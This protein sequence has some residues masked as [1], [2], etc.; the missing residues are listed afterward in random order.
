MPRRDV[1]EWF[2]QVGREMASLAEE[3]STGR[4]RVAGGRCWEPRVDLFEE[5]ARLLLRVELAG[6]RGEDIALHFVPERHALVVRGVRPDTLPL[7]GGRRA[8]HQLEIM[9][10]EF[11][12]EIALPDISIDAG[13][14]RA[15]VRNGMLLVSIPKLDRFVVT[16]TTIVGEL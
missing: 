10:G 4:P 7:E 14:I 13:A 15:Q 3:M 12:R 9:T 5:D 1:E 2:V 8:A 11:S 16:R 6:V